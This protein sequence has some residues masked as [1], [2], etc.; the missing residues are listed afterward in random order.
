[1]D[2]FMARK[3]LFSYLPM[4]VMVMS[5]SSV[6]T[7][8]N[9]II[10][11]DLLGEGIARYIG[12]ASV[13]TMVLSSA[14]A[15]LT[16]GGTLS[17]VRHRAR[18]DRRGAA[19]VFTITLFACVVC[20][21]AFSAM[22]VYTA[23]AYEIHLEP[24]MKREYLLGLAR[25]AVPVMVLQAVLAH[26]WMDH[27]R[28]LSV[29]CFVVYIVSEPYIAY[30]LYEDSLLTGIASAPAYAAL[31][32]LLLVP[33]H[34]RVRGRYMKLGIPVHSQG[35]PRRRARMLG[36]TLV[37]RSSMIIRY[38]FLHAFIAA[39]ATYEY[40]CLSSQTTVFHFIVP[41]FSGCALLTAVLTGLSYAQGDRS[42]TVE[43]VKTSLLTG[44]VL[45]LTAMVLVLVQSEWLNDTLLSMYDDK[46]SALWCLRFFALSIPTTTLSVSLTY[47]FMSSGR[48][49]RACITLFFRG[50]VYMILG[51]SVM[52]GFLGYKAIWASFLFCD[53]AALFS[54]L[55]SSCMRNR[56]FPAGLDDLLVLD[57]AFPRDSVCEE[58]VY[59]LREFAPRVPAILREAGVS[60]EDV[61]EASD[62]VENLLSSV[63]ANRGH[64]RV[65]VRR[66]KGVR[67]TVQDYSRR[68]IEVPEGV[69]TK[70]A[71]GI[72]TY[73][74]TF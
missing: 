18:G 57:E 34:Y 54:L 9:T 53:I 23:P 44:L 15:F 49:P 7:S 8:I 20:G 45:S 69:K 30:R 26:L 51:V 67:V 25:T 40:H 55:V 16:L 33:L 1:M 13:Y 14:A 28:E 58:T 35:E 41:M 37:N 42:G 36:R 10:A 38:T 65:I 52:S 70:R 32:A 39:A 73:V 19:G 22:C 66:A 48:G 68:Q 21:A 72:N 60:E 29:L 11:V 61:P 17:F 62:K 63:Y 46:D 24:M 43:T 6:V 3:V 50:A 47:V 27:D 74:L 12:D 56:R 4:A 59:D 31:V 5:V 64:M 2:G 71:A